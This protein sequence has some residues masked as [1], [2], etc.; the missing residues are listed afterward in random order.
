MKQLPPTCSMDAELAV[1]DEKVSVNLT[2]LPL[3]RPARRSSW[4]RC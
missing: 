1:G 2:I 3:I 4:A